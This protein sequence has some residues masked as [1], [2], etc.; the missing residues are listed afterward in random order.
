MCLN[1]QSTILYVGYENGA[2]LSWDYLKG[3]VI[4]ENKTH[5]KHIESLI[6]STNETLLLS[7][8]QDYSVKVF[9]TLKEHEEDKNKQQQ[10]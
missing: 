3:K 5:T 8:S 1:K 9:K 10:Q 7:C 4:N 2:I 6:L